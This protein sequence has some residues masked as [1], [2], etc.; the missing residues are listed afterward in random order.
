MFKLL[1]ISL[2]SGSYLDSSLK[3]G[4]RNSKYQLHLHFIT[5]FPLRLLSDIYSSE[6]Y[7]LA[8]NYCS[9][10]CYFIIVKWLKGMNVFFS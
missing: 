5:P 6:F 2:T 4:G 10:V 9:T 8:F 1:F 3:P 7:I